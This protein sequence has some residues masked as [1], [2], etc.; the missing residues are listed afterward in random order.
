MFRKNLHDQVQTFDSLAE[1]QI[2]Q[3]KEQVVQWNKGFMSV[4]DPTDTGF[5]FN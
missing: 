1:S 4:K 5:F 2:D 3:V